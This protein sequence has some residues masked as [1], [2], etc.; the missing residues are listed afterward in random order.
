MWFLLSDPQWRVISD[1]EVTDEYPGQQLAVYGLVQNGELS[2]SHS[3]LKNLKSEMLSVDALNR[4]SK[5]KKA[6]QRA[7]LCI[8]ESEEL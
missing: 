5:V 2:Q 4:R 7:A 1:L 6:E 3:S 8:L